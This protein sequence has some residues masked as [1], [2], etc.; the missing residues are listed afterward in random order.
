MTENIQIN[1]KDW[2]QVP[3]NSAQYMI[4]SSYGNT[5][6]RYSL[7]TTPNNDEYHSLNNGDTLSGIP[8]DIWL[9][10]VDNSTLTVAVSKVD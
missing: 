8:Q 9:K 5:T 3:I 10:S 4:I 1:N 7:S 6:I 2:T